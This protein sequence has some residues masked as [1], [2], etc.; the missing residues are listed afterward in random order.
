MKGIA[1]YGMAKFEGNLNIDH[2]ISGPIHITRIQFCLMVGIVGITAFAAPGMGGSLGSTTGADENIT[3]HPAIKSM[4]CT[5]RD[6]DRP[7]IGYGTPDVSGNYNLAE[8]LR[9]RLNNL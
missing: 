3:G 1:R 6:I 4:T 8:V 2:R 9:R 5:D 7:A